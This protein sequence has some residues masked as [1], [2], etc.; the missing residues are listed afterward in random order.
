MK[1]L[2]KQYPSKVQPPIERYEE[3]KAKTNQPKL[4]GGTDWQKIN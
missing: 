3:Q 4:I 1:F 2:E